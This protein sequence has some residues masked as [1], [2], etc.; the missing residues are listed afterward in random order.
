MKEVTDFK[1]LSKEI[2]KYFKRGVITN[3]FLSPESLK[4]EIKEGNLFY[5]PGEDSL[6]I[7][8]K[9][10]GFYRLYFYALNDGVLFGNQEQKT[11]CDF[12]GD[13]HGILKN[14]GFLPYLLR[15]RLA[16]E[17]SELNKMEAAKGEI[18]DLDEIFALS[19]SAFDRYS[20]YTPTKEELKSDILKERIYIRTID[21][22]IAGFLRYGINGKTAEIKHLCTN[23]RF[24][25][26]GVARTLLT[27]FLSENEKS[28]VWTGA[29]NT[30]ALALYQSMGFKKDGY[31]STV[32]I[33]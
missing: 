14:N 31:Q 8:V 17:K 15:V 25:R 13:D 2:M 33:K 3:N 27:M 7:F 24:R 32:Y 1:A 23:E 21:G 20:G 29:E 16:C 4:C 19:E 10:S 6:E 9:R 28:V 18:R 22:K 30:A 5:E 12:S 26:K 11:V